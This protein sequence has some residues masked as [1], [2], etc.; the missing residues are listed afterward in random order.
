[1]SAVDTDARPTTPYRVSA[2][3]RAL[4]V[5]WRSSGPCL[6]AIVVM[7]LIQAG[8]MYLNTPSGFTPAFLLAFAVSAVAALGLYAVLSAGA[9]RAV[10]AGGPSVLERVRAGLGSFTVWTA[11][12]WVVMLAVSTVSVLLIPQVAL[13]TPYLPLAAMDGRRNALGA[14]L[15]AIGQRPGRWVITGL[16][17]LVG[18]L[19]LFLLSIANTLFVQGTPAALFFWLGIGLVAWW[20]LTAWALIWRGT[21]AGAEAGVRVRAEPDPQP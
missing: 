15:R 17:L 18:G 4:R 13:L 16:I 6:A 1:M 20:L 5:M 7:A 10:D 3:L 11:L 9:L 8:L 21:P 12:Q 2:L 19:V 14:N